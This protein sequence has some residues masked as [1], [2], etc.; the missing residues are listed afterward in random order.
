MR[1][2]DRLRPRCDSYG[3]VGGPVRSSDPPSSCG[4]SADGQN[5]ARK[6]QWGR[7]KRG[8]TNLSVRMWE[9]CGLWC[10]VVFDACFALSHTMRRGISMDLDKRC[11]GIMRWK[12]TR[13]C[14][15]KST[16]I[17]IRSWKQEPKPRG[18]TRSPIFVFSP[19][20][21]PITW[22]T[23][24]LGKFVRG[25]SIFTCNHKAV[26]ADN[27]TGNP[28]IPSRDE[29]LARPVVKLGLRRPG[30][31]QKSAAAAAAAT[32]AAAYHLESTRSSRRTKTPQ[33]LLSRLYPFSLF[34]LFPSRLSSSLFE[35]P[36][37]WCR[38]FLLQ[39]QK[40]SHHAMTERA[41]GVYQV[42]YR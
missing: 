30:A 19:E 7:D 2:G 40:I 23:E 11:H 22:R 9:G 21:L 36:T 27:Y 41:W 34:H 15:K 35:F 10:F 6:L 14:N 31:W 16:G 13:G 4:S 25:G 8:S 17:L 33:P 1:T 5:W 32:A 39:H 12:N 18:T 3:E 42:L 24:W 28:F 37:R 29:V 20:G 38:L 26:K